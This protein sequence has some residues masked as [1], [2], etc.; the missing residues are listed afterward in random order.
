MTPAMIPKWSKRSTVMASTLAPPL[1]GSESSQYS[2]QD[3][4]FLRYAH[5]LNVGYL[6]TIPEFL[7]T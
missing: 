3:K 6:E 4:S 2:G 7:L 5:L 1:N